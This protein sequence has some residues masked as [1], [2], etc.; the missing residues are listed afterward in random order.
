MK[1]GL[2]PHHMHLEITESSYTGYSSLNMLS[3]M[4]ICMNLEITAEGVEHSEQAKRLRDMNCDQAQGY[5]FSR[6]VPESEF[7]A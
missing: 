2:T 3:E 7:I 4:P 6:P 5:F 1:Y